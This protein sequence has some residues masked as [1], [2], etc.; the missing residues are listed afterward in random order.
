VPGRERCRGLSFTRATHDH[1]RETKQAARQQFR[2]PASSARVTTVQ[3][4]P[5]R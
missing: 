2:G 4:Q 5:L 3:R 1:D